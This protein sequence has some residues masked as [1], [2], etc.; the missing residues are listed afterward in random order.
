MEKNEVY[1]DKFTMRIMNIKSVERRKLARAH[2]CRSRQLIRVLKEEIYSSGHWYCNGIK[3]V[4][5]E[6]N[7]VWIS[8]LKSY[9]IIY[10]LV[11][12]CFKF[13]LFV[14]IN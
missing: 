7:W 3:Q 13:L 4:S 2:L 11:I 10:E 1:F 5:E 9:K 12:K 14:T 8:S 6:L